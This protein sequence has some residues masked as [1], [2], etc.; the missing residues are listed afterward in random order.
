MTREFGPLVPPS[1]RPLLGK[2]PVEQFKAREFAGLVI[3]QKLDWA[4]SDRNLAPPAKKFAY[5]SSRPGFF[6]PSIIV[7]IGTLVLP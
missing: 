1:P 5:Q 6:L 3:L 2:S 4:V 7:F